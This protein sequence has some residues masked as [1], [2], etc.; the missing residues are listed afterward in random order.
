[1]LDEHD[2][3]TDARPVPAVRWLVQVRG[4]CGTLRIAA[5]C[6][7][8]EAAEDQADVLRG[9]GLDTVIAWQRG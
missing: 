5:Q 7:T 1:M 2:T 3:I 9:R 8:R 6:A 4:P